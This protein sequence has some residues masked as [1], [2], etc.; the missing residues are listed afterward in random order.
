MLKKILSIAGKTVA[1]ILLFYFFLAFV[2]IPVGLSWVIQD[3]GTKILRHPVSVRAV[4]FNPF[5]LRLSIY[6]LQIQDQDKSSLVAF[7]RFSVD[8]SFLALLKKTYRVEKVSLDALQ[9][10]AALL[11]GGRINLMDL[12]PAVTAPSGDMHAAVQKPA[13]MPVVFVD[14]ID[15]THGKVIFTDKTVQPNFVSTMGDMDIHVTG[16]STRPD[17]TAKVVF[18]AVIDGKGRISTETAIKPFAQP[19]QLETSFSLDGYPLTVVGPYTGKYTGR[20]MKDGRLDLK[21]DYRIADN[22]LNA[23]HKVL[24]QSFEF[25]QKVESK[26]AL[27][28]PFGL[29]VALLEDPQGRIKISLPVSGD[30]SKP[31]FH[32][33][34]LVGQVVRNFF[35]TLVT[36]PFTFLASMLGADSGTEEL[37]R[38]RFIPGQVALTQEE[39]TKL[40]L[41]VRGLRERPR[42]HLEI[43]GG[44]DPVAD[45]KAIK[46]DALA[47]DYQELRSKSS[48]SDSWIYQMLYQ[49]RFGIRDLWVLTK[50]YKVKEGN[51]ED[52][53]LV[54][55]VKRQLVENAPPDKAALNALAF[56]RS[57]I[58]YDYLVSAGLDDVHV[59]QGI[60]RE[61]PVSMGLVATEF[62][63]T[64][65]EDKKP[66]TQ[67]EQ[68]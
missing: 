54:A 21:M 66:D 56:S 52:A 35:M 18:G 48:K 15:I 29:A 37:G 25:G 8:V 43:N 67:G 68:K 36:K 20:D 65:F 34:Q 33:W 57:K 42:L 22:Q 45:W 63:L 50:K 12:I 53:A 62:T 58:I 26:D 1:G 47:R 30:M 44:Y 5:L 60:T 59:S 3:Q 23:T 24:I 64:V 13:A 38:V 14:C 41:L 9:I 4:Q 28:L 11:S 39:K 7:D 32:Y 10:N 55:E 19:L 16:L 61:A 6:G 51:Y 17:D 27:N 46:T 2:L 40:D 31:D 49:R